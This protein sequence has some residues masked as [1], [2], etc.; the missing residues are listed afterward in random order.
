MDMGCGCGRALQAES[1]PGGT[2]EAEV[3]EVRVCQ[4][5]QCRE[6]PGKGLELG[7]RGL[8]VPG[9]LCARGVLG[10]S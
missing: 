5:A 8:G 9:T 1:H 3:G 4:N 7:Q 6:C 2:A 10:S